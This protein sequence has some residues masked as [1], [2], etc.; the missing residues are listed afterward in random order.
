MLPSFKVANTP[1]FWLGA[2]VFLLGV[3]IEIASQSGWISADANLISR[4]G[5]FGAYLLGV[6]GGV[7]SREKKNSLPPPKS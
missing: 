2:G 5:A 4:I 6:E 1:T 3:F 7:S